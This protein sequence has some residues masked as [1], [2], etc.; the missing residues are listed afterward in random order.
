M[1]DWSLFLA[2]VC[3]PV[4]LVGDGGGMRAK[5]CISWVALRRFDAEKVDVTMFM[6]DF[7]GPWVTW[8]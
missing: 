2:L 3:D 7:K 1:E 4:V 5:D 6:A 8:C